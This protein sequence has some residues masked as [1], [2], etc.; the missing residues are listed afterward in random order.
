MNA[1]SGIWLD[2]DIPQIILQQIIHPA[3]YSSYLC[4]KNMLIYY[5]Q[6]R[7]AKD[8]D[9]NSFMY[10]YTLRSGRKHFCQYCLQVFRT[11]D[12]LKC[13]INDCFKING[14]QRIND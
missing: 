9:F 13:R 6:K 7:E 8:T 10:N 14:N 5:C 1:V 4:G 2:P 12:L 3:N 11:A